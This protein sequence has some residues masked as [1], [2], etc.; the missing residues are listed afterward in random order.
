MDPTLVPHHLQPHVTPSVR[1]LQ[2]EYSIPCTTASSSATPECDRLRAEVA[3]L[4]HCCTM[5]RKRA[6]VHAAATLGLVG[7]TRVARDGAIKMKAERDEF[8]KKYLALK[9]TFEETQSVYIAV[10][11]HSCTHDHLGH[12]RHSHLSPASVRSS[13]RRR[14]V[15]VRCRRGPHHALH[16]ACPLL[17]R[18]TRATAR[19]A[20]SASLCRSGSA[21]SASTCRSSAPARIPLVQSRLLRCRS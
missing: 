3:S 4:R 2:L 1:K 12:C 14:W 10:L 7:L 17:L 21:R 20:R 18:A 9:Q 13:V 8:E 15:S 11:V 5:W 19:I 6:A 16:S